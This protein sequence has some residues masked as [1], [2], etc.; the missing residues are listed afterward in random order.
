MGIQYIQ[1]QRSEKDPTSPEQ[2]SGQGSE[3]DLNPAPKK[4]PTNS[5]GGKSYLKK[6]KKRQRGELHIF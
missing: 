4:Y 2:C 5:Q 1:I 3:A 6:K